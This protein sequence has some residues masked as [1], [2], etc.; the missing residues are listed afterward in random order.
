[1][2]FKKLEA[3]ESLSEIIKSAFDMELAVA[4]AW[5]YTKEEA[6]VIEALPV[7]LTQ[8]EHTLASMRTHIEMSMT[9]SEDERYGSI[10]LNEVERT[11]VIEESVRYDKV[12]YEIGAMLESAYKTF[13]DEYKSGFGTE[14]FDMDA[15]FKRRKESTLKRVVA[16]W[17]DV[18]KV[19]NED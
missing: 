13:I 19:T 16:V 11:E 10:N 18:T 17:F 1:M 8:I 15:H 9:L 14:D 12:T 5:G 4:G 2:E 7:S 3:G 6:T